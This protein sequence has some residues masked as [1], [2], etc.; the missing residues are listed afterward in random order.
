MK[1]KMKK[2]A[3]KSVA[4][5]AAMGEMPMPM[6]ARKSPAKAARGKPPKAMYGLRR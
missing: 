6:M 2:A 3:P 4:P 1:K 5:E